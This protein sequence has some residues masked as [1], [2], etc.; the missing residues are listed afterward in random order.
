MGLRDIV[1]FLDS[2]PASEERLRLATRVA[3]DHAAHLRAVFVH[4]DQAIDFSPGGAGGSGLVNQLVQTVAGTRR[5]AVANGSFELRLRDSLHWFGGD[6]SWHEVDAAG[7]ARLIACTRAADL[8]ILGQSSRDVRPGPPWRPDDIV[9][10]S[11]CPVLMVPYAGAF[12]EIGRRVLVAWDGSRE[13]ARALNDALPLIG[14]ASAVTVMMARARDS[15]L[16]RDREATQRVVRH[17]ARH[18]IHA[19]AD[20]PLRN[21]TPVSDILLSAATDFCADLIVAGAYHHSPL[22]EALIGGVS[23]GLLQHMTVPMLMSH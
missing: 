4:H 9:V 21:G 18:D 16:P 5:S 13:A 20:H 19:R 12:D 15:D 17:L 3:R 2:S 6:S 10:E 14:N 7:S 23:R 22:R 1:V 8:V 11:G